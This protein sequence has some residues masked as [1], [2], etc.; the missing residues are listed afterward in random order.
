MISNIILVA[1]CMGHRNLSDLIGDEITN[2]VMTPVVIL[3]L[4]ITV[5]ALRK[6]RKQEYNALDD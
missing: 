3:F 6:R 5:I 2:L 1:S 4:L